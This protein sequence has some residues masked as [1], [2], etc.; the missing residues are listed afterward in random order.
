MAELTQGASSGGSKVRERVRERKTVGASCSQADTGGKF[1]RFQAGLGTEFLS[2]LN[3]SFF[4]VILKNA[5]FFY[6]LF[7]VFGAF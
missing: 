4:C 1:R 5:T 3:A 6:I 7:R 2:V